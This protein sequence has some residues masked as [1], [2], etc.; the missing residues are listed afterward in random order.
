MR[1]LLELYPQAV[2][3]GNPAANLSSEW[4]RASRILRDIEFTCP[5]VLFATH[6]TSRPR[7]T[8]EHRFHSVPASK[9]AFW[10]A[11]LAKI[12]PSHAGH[13]LHSLKSP[14]VFLYHLNKTVVAGVLSSDGFPGLG[15][16]HLADIPYIFDEV[17]RFN[18]TPADT[19]LAK[20]IS[21]SWSRFA[22]S[23]HPSSSRGTTIKDWQAAWAPETVS[24]LK[25]ARVMVIGGPYSGM[26]RLEG[27]KD[28]LAD[29]R[30]AER[31][32]FILR[33]KVLRE[34]GL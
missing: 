10:R 14:P 1:T 25:K 4:T 19:V 8:H 34:I 33:E 7:S 3:D 30:L 5:S 16:S 6:T 23:G 32:G 29:Q 31:C 12:F 11:A 21:G 22:T 9:Q 13:Y 20:Q 24:L 18:A 26:S 2:F 27:V 15:I 17:A 28:S